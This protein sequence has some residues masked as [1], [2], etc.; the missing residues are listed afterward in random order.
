MWWTNAEKLKIPSPSEALPGRRDWQMPVPEKHEVLGTSMTPPFPGMATAMFG[1]GC[2][3]GAEKRFWR[4]SG[5]HSTQAGYAGGP[6]P[7]P[8]LPRGLY[9]THGT[10]RGVPR[11]EPRRVLRAS[12]EPGWRVRESEGRFRRLLTRY[13]RS[14]DESC[15]PTEILGR[16]V[17]RYTRLRHRDSLTNQSGFCPQAASNPRTIF[18]RQSSRPCLAPLPTLMARLVQTVPTR[19][20]T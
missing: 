14:G 18:L 1:L 19:S 12:G 13:V 17:V 4:V 2:F 10:Q 6:T 7:N 8:N 16:F 5:V 9:R 3:W 11:Q 20:P 15:H